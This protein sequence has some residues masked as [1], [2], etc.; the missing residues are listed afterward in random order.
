VVGFTRSLAR[1]DGDF[2]IRV[3][4]ICPELVGT[5]L[6]VAMGQNVMT[7]QEMASL[8]GHV[9][10]DYCVALVPRRL[11]VAPVPHASAPAEMA[12]TGRPP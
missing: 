1:L 10:H 9:D 12:T 7:M 3:N 8:H 11:A 2:G 6:G 4:A 5:P